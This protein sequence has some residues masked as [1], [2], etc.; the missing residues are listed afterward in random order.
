MNRSPSSRQRV[1]V[2]V[3]AVD[4][5]RVGD[6]QVHVARAAHLEVRE[7][8]H[9][10]RGEAALRGDL[11][12]EQL[13]QGGAVGRLQPVGGLEGD[14]ELPVAHLGLDRVDG[15]ARSPPATATWPRVSGSSRCWRADRVVRERR[16]Q[17]LEPAVA[18]GPGRLEGLAEDVE[19]ELDRGVGH[20]A[21]RRAPARPA[22]AAP[23]AARSRPRARATT[24]RRRARA[25]LRSRCAGRRSVERSGT[26]AMSA[27]PFCSPISG[28]A[29]VDVLLVVVDV[30]RA[31][32]LDAAG[33][34]RRGRRP[35]ARACP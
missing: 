3:E 8:R 10:R 31:R 29:L 20:E 4:A 26:A 7:P 14:L 12:D 22:G 27:Q 19:L 35:P 18:L 2:G 5:V 9:E 25:R 30:D 16:V 6:R 32:D 15:D 21:A 17:R 33:Q 23:R 34:V 13:G 28:E 11:A 1:A 24:T